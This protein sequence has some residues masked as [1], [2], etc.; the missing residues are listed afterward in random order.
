MIAVRSMVASEMGSS[1]RKK[2][3][4]FYCDKIIFI[5]S[6]VVIVVYTL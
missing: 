4:N 2:R 1:L 5:L 3:G 6:G